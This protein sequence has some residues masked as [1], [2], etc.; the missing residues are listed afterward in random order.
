MRRVHFISG[1]IITTFILWHLFNHVCSIF[2]VSQHLEMMRTLRFFYR[3][4]FIE[5]ILLGAVGVQIVSGLKL[6]VKKRKISSTF[7]E[8]IQIWSGMYLAIFF[9]IHLSAVFVG[10]HFLHLD[11]NFYFGTAGVNT[12]PLNLFFIP[13]YALAIMAFF[14]HLAAIHH[15]KMKYSFLGLSPRIQS[16]LILLF[17]ICLTISIFYGL[18]N[19]FRGVKIPSAYHILLGK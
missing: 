8:K 2:G 19:K 4:I 13:Y 18:T 3:N 1:L 10:R 5:T 14:G 15:K 11:T 16:N 12:F 6:F 17:G 7:M 9:V